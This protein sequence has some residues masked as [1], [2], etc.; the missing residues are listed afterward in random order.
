MIYS[1]VMKAKQLLIKETAVAVAMVLVM[2]VAKAEQEQLVCRVLDKGNGPKIYI[3]GKTDPHHWV[4]VRD[5]IRNQPLSHD[6]QT[7]DIP[8]TPT[9]DTKNCAVEIRMENKPGLFEAR[10][11]RLVGSDGSVHPLSGWYVPA[12]E[13]QPFITWTLE[14]SKT[15]GTL[16]MDFTS[17]ASHTPGIFEKRSLD[18]YSNRKNLKKGVTYRIQMDARAEGIAFFR[19]S[20]HIQGDA[21]Y[22]AWLEELPPADWHELSSGVQVEM[23]GRYGAHFVT[24]A[25]PSCWF[26][27]PDD[28]SAAIQQAHRIL[29]ANPHALLVPRIQLDVPP[30]WFAKHPED[31]VV[32]HDGT[33]INERHGNIS[34]EAYRRDAFAYLT[35]YIQALQ[36]AFPRNFAGVHPAMQNTSECFYPESWSKMCG[37]DQHTL[38][39]WRK[40]LRAR[41]AKDW[42]RAEVPTP[43]E[44]RT[45]H[46]QNRV[47]DVADPIQARCV[48]FA[49][50]QQ[51]EMVRFIRDTCRLCR[52]V[53]N[54][55]KLVVIFYGYTW[56]FASIHQGPAASGHYGIGHLLDTIGD[57]LDIISS[58]LSYDPDR[59]YLGSTPIMHPAETFMRHGILPVYEDD[60]RTHLDQRK[61]QAVQEGVTMNAHETCEMLTRNK[62]VMAV[63]GFES[64]WMDLMGQGWFADESIWKICRDLTLADKANCNR[65]KAYNPPVALIHDEESIMRI[66]FGG[67]NFFAP[68]SHSSRRMFAR[69]GAG[70]GQYLLSDAVRKPLNAKLEVH[71]SSWALDADTISRLAADRMKR[72]DVT[73]VWCW[74]P[75]CLTDHGL[76]VASGE[77]LTGFRLRH[78][79][80]KLPH[81][82][83]TAAGLAI[84]LPASLRC[85]D[86]VPCNTLLTIEPTRDDLI[87]AT[88]P[89]GSPA[90]AA[91]RNAG[92]TGWSVFYGINCFDVPS[93]TALTR[94]AGIFSHFANNDGQATLSA[95]D[96]LLVLQQLA[97]GQRDI[98]FP[99]MVHV[100]DAREQRD[101]GMSNRFSFNLKQ[102][103]VKILLVIP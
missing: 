30:W 13:H 46:G 35:K 31:K 14:A 16:R 102:G 23:A 34:S 5:T 17:T 82:T 3:D 50:F 100:L 88:W 33:I 45:E 11:M 49:R 7:F 86:A 98:I 90:I 37:Y 78:S 8:V 2:V 22:H 70:F 1:V 65:T 77:R 32:L 63:H 64:W 20:I 101:L 43:A 83:A 27:G 66:D 4:W 96:N 53:T 61:S 42:E 91:R 71:L 21:N 48:E 47:F 94:A 44:R 62:G 58:P 9:A 52:E 69:T 25:T 68:L 73:R 74:L 103:D 97:D 15:C 85:K 10:N 36:T 40:W 55:K 57:N 24:Y 93:A 28:F 60:S 18:I 29:Q 26:D 51:E 6:W 19:P 95:S 38:R 89:D 84:G 87:W 41:G 39:A 79:A 59:R 54:G 67:K 81:A 12:K 75:G 99:S 56:E 76:D 92:G 72:P 80:N